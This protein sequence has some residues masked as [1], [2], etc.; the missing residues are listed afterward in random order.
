MICASLCR[1]VISTS[2]PRLVF[3]GSHEPNAHTGR[4]TDG[5]CID[6]EDVVFLA[7][8]G[9]RGFIQHRFR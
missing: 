6:I 3:G 4:P 1:R 7:V 9:L 5:M 8:G 2:A